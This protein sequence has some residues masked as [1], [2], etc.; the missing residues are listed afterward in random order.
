MQSVTDQNVAKQVTDQL[1]AA[2]HSGEFP[3]GTRLV[4]R[5]LAA[6]LGVSHIPI[7]EALAR[8]TEE[9]L[10][11]REPR[12]GARVAE[13]SE[14]DLEEISSLR[15]VL[16][17]FTALRVRDRWEDSFA[18]SLQSIIDEMWRVSPEDSSSLARLDQQFHE[19]LAQLAQHKVLNDVSSGLRG[20]VQGFLHEAHVRLSE[21]AK[22]AHI[23]SHQELLDAIARGD[24]AEIERTV[25]TH[26]MTAA[27]RIAAE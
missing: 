8:L 15:V 27:Q 16:E 17:K 12:R 10:V 18:E 23:D 19:K 5:Q 21:D 3:P 14:S 7:R 20:R 4:E 9:G 26:I 22:K 25:E 2:I 13:L 1:R 24:T 6:Q 11:V